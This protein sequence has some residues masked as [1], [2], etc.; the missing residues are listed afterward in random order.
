MWWQ[1]WW[2]CLQRG[3]TEIDRGVHR[4]QSHTQHQK[5]LIKNPNQKKLIMDFRK[6]QVVHSPRNINGERVERVAN[7]K[8]LVTH[9]SEDLTWTANTTA[10]AQQRL[11]FL[12]LL[13]KVNLSQQLLE[14]FYHCSIE[15]I[16]TYGILV[17][18]GGSSAA[19][20]KFRLRDIKTAQIIINQQLPSLDDIFTSCCLQKFHN[21]LKD[22]F[23]PAY[24]L[25]ELLPSGK[26][27]RSIKTRITRFMNSFYPK[28]IT[29]LNS[30]LKTHTPNTGQH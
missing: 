5:R 8:F 29:T 15:S 11:H 22:S 18:Y 28:A 27:Y 1:R 23:H 30:E 19:D 2:V 4:E 3:G 14:S 6:K 9:I 24:H 21:I 17:W 10:K 26:C 12:R 16:L 25:F 20:K 7:F 13:N